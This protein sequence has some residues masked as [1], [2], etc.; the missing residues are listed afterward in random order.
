MGTLLK[1]EPRNFR[2]VKT[3]DVEERLKDFISIA[4]LHK[5]SLSDVIN[6]AKIMEMER[7]N[8]LFVANGDIHDEQMAGIGE[9][10]TEIKSSMSLISIS[11]DE[12]R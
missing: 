8:N 12:S 5:V 3:E 9:I 11:L 2:S 7:S 4:K 10:L 1:Q 6:T